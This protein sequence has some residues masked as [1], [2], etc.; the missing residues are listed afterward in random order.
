MNGLFPHRSLASTPLYEMRADLAPPLIVGAGPEGVR[1]IYHVTGGSF[2][3]TRLRGRVLPSGADWAR[4][5]SDTSIVIDVRA[6]LETHDG[7]VISLAYYG[8]LVIPSELQ[9]RVLD[10]S[11]GEA[12]DPA[13][14]YFRV[15]PTF[16]TADSRYVWLNGILAVGVG[17]VVTGGVAYSVHQID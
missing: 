17:R 9:S 11:T 8:R 12:V 6:A 4:I 5:R 13:A 10:L 15:A 7:A 2:E 14:Y 1:A 16:E 3:G